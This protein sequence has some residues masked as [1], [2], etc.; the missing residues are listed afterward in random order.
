MGKDIEVEIF[1]DGGN[2][3]QKDLKGIKKSTDVVSKSFSKA[4][5]SLVS[6]NAGFQ[7]LAGGIRIASR[8]IGACT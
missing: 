5:A 2:K 8:A 7:L 1:L 4:Q 3:F 6:L